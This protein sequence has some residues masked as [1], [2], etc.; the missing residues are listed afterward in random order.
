MAEEARTTLAPGMQVTPNVHLVKP[1]GAGGMG[2]V[3]LANDKSLNR[4]VVVK[5]MLGGFDAS[6]AAKQRFKREAAAAAAVK[7]EHV[8]KMYAYGVTDDGL[9]FIVMEHLEGRD[10]GAVLAERG[11]LEKEVV[12]TIVTQV[13][14]ALGKVHA[15][16]LLHRDVKPDNIFLSETGDIDDDEVFVKLLDFGIAKSATEQ[17]QEGTLDG[18]T[19]TGQV[20][21]TPFYM[22]PEQVTAQ[23]VIDARA[24]LWALGIVTFELLTGKRPF[25]GPSF[26]ALAV[27]IAT[28]EPLKASEIKPELGEAFD[29]WFAKA[30]AREAK[31]RFATARQMADELRRA[32]GIAGAHSGVTSDSGRR[33]LSS[34]SGSRS[35]P[36]PDPSTPLADSRPREASPSFGLASTI[37]EVATPDPA[38]A[39][40]RTTEPSKTPSSAGRGYRW[41]S[42]AGGAVALF[43]GAFFVVRFVARDTIDKSMNHA[44]SRVDDPVATTAAAPAATPALSP[45]A[46]VEAPAAA[47]TSDARL[48]HD[49]GTQVRTQQPV[50][51][52][53]QVKASPRLP[54][55]PPATAKPSADPVKPPTPPA[56]SGSAKVDVF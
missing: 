22:S 8:V 52:Q 47:S 10:L 18:G 32:L 26:G 5:F 54:A 11:C 3:W 23:K 15:A 14:K 37:N 38:R 7:S 51:A 56:P 29:Q 13:A 49:A 16:G 34:S 43:T 39:T 31:D 33:G 40:A 44:S 6:P 36:S 2:A 45:V 53:A 19:K 30:C 41:I 24:D 35:V 17:P 12:A 46:I 9:A 48:V 27:R 20:V 28:G 55:A 4:E 1:L 25:D 42:L 50:Q 21:G